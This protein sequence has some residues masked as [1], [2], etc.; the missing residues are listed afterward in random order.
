MTDPHLL[1]EHLHFQG[2]GENPAALRLGLQQAL[3]QVRLHPARLP[4]HAILVIRH[5]QSRTP[6]GLKTPQMNQWQQQVQSQIDDLARRA[7]RP[8]R[9]YIPPDAVSVL[10]YDDVELLVCYTRDTLARRTAWYWADL[11]PRAGYPAQPTGSQLL[12]GWE[13]YPQAVPHTLVALKPHEVRS[14]LT[15]LNHSQLSRLAHLLH[16][17]F[18]LPSAVLETAVPHSISDSPTHENQAL[19]FDQMAVPSQSLPAAPWHNWLP[20]QLYQYLSPQAE[21]ILGLCH[22]LVQRPQQARQPRFA[23]ETRQ[24]LEQTAFRPT[25]ERPIESNAPAVRPSTKQPSNQATQLPNHPSPITNHQETT[26]LTNLPLPEGTH[27]SLGGAIFLV[28]VLT[29]L[30]LPAVIPAL[31]ELNPWA[32]LG[33]VSAALLSN[34]FPLHQ[35]DPLWSMVNELAGLEVEEIWGREL[36]ESD[37][38]SLLPEWLVLLPTTPAVCRLERQ[39]GR[40]RLWDTA[41]PILL[42][43]L[44]DNPNA[45]ESLVAAYKEAGI[46]MI[47]ESQPGWTELQTAANP[48]FAP[49]LAWHVARLRPFLTHLLETLTGFSAAAILHQPATLYISR[50]HVDLRLSLEQITIPLRRAGLDRTPG[51]QPEFGYIVTIY[52]E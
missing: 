20:P 29:R 32:L 22:T 40:L 43:D 23:Q 9:Q 45:S 48:L 34:H 51:W 26:S 2:S 21:Y 24:W 17:T 31:A 42:A 37:N 12:T 30:R 33:A 50:T 46:S 11:F 3:R 13:A 8:G 5:L 52:F 16:H 38:F 6:F 49:N 4:P 19:T 35:S 7:F 36:P 1:I 18:A 44:P 15:S 27:T 14:A 25:A 10:F 41:A 28:N 39:N 47:I